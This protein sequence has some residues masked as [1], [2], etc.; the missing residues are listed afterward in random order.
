MQK[1]IPALSIFN[2]V[3]AYIRQHFNL[4]PMTSSQILQTSTKYFSLAIFAVNWQS[5]LR[6]FEVSARHQTDIFIIIVVTF[7]LGIYL[8]NLD[9]KFI[10]K[11]LGKYK[12]VLRR[13]FDYSIECILCCRLKEKE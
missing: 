10:R 12:N 4:Y 6:S 2:Q 7:F 8:V 9:L 3:L 5:L 13:V 11:K 1:K